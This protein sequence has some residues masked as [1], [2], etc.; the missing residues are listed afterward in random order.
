MQPKNRAFNDAIKELWTLN[1]DE[2]KVDE[3][4]CILKW[5]EKYGNER[6]IFFYSSPWG[7]GKSF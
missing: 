7:G 4:N 2:W 5:V 3:K 1:V 6:K